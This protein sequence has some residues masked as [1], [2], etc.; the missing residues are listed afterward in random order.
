[1]KT[2]RCR[3][4]SQTPSRS[5]FPRPFPPEARRWRSPFPAP[6][7]DFAGRAG[8][9]PPGA[10]AP[11][12]ARRRPN[13]PLPALTPGNSSGRRSLSRGSPGHPR[14]D[15]TGRRAG[16]VPQALRSSPAAPACGAEPAA[17][18][19]SLPA[20]QR[21]A[22]CSASPELR[23]CRPE[24]CRG[25]CW[26]PISPPHPPSGAFA[27]EEQP[28]NQSFLVFL[29]TLWSVCTVRGAAGCWVGDRAPD[30]ACPVPQ[31][32][33]VHS[34]HPGPRGG[35]R[36]RSQPPAQGELLR[37]PGFA[38]W[39]LHLLTV[40]SDDG[41]GS[42]QTEFPAGAW[43]LKASSLWLGGRDTGLGTGTWVCF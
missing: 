29:P 18:R 42:G 1:M 12:S 17:E 30:G 3:P 14:R 16:T 28:S 32:V 40:T 33:W 6:H 36:G 9:A 5:R 20:P 25:S 11:A 13:A 31:A 15:P 34:S 4:C 39:C 41:P 10:G 37:A 24:K 38:G 35:R 7:L 8:Q 43:A 22:G 27:S 26:E 21:A 2:R 23:S 19:G